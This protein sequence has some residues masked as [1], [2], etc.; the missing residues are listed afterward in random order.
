MAHEECTPVDQG[1]R[2]IQE[3]IIGAETSPAEHFVLHILIN[4]GGR[5]RGSA[6]KDAGTCEFYLS[7]CAIPVTL[8]SSL[9]PVGEFAL[10]RHDGDTAKGYNFTCDPERYRR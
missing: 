9:D 5:Y 1:P 4:C 8:A 7:F 10:A 3:E 2:R 6:N